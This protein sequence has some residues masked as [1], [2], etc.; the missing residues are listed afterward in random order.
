M[1]KEHIIA[2]LLY[3][4]VAIFFLRGIL[5]SPG[6]LIGSDWGLPINP[7]QMYQGFRGAFWT[8]TNEGDLLGRHIITLN[9][10]LFRLF[11]GLL[12]VFQVSGEWLTKGLAIFLLSAP[13]FS[14]YCL[15]RYLRR[16]P[17]A[18]FLAGLFYMTTPPVFNYLSMGWI[19][20]LLSFVLL[21]LG[22]ITF[23]KTVKQRSVGYGV[24]TALIYS[25]VLFQLQALSWF[26]IVFVLSSIFVVTS[27]ETLKDY[28]KFLGFVFLLTFLFNSYWIMPLLFEPSLQSSISLYDFARFGI[29]LNSLDM[30]RLWGSVFNFQFETALP[31]SLVVFTFLLPIFAYS[32]LIL[33]NKNRRILFFAILSFVPLGIFWARQLLLF[34][35]YSQIFRDYSRNFILSALAYSALLAFTLDALYDWFKKNKIVSF[36]FI[37]LFISTNILTSYPFWS[38]GLAKEAKLERDVRLK[39]IQF[40]PEYQRVE[41]WLAEEEGDFKVLW[42]PTGGGV[43]AFRDKPKTAGPYGAIWDLFAGLARKPGQIAV[44]DRETGYGRDFAE[45]IQRNIYADKNPYLADILS[46]ANIKYLVVRLNAYDDP[47]K[48]PME[49]IYHKLE[50]DDKFQE[51]LVDGSVVVF[52]NKKFLSHFYPSQNII[53]SDGNIEGLSDVVSFDNWSIRSAIFLADN[54]DEIQR[55]LMK[56]ANEFF[57]E[58]KLENVISEKKLAKNELHPENIAFPYVRWKPGGLIYSLV[59]KKEQF[60]EW[61]ARDN[62]EELLD[63]KLFYASKRISEIEKWEKDIDLDKT[64][65]RYKEKMEEALGLLREDNWQDKKAL[66][67]NILNTETS[68]G[69]HWEKISMMEFDEERIEKAKAIFKELQDKVKHL[70]T[71]YDFTERAYN[72]E[73]PKEGSYQLLIKNEE[74]SRYFRETQ[75]ELDLLGEKIT[76]PLPA[77]KDNWISGG[78]FRLE[79]GEQELKLTK[80]QIFNLLGDS[81]WQD[82]LAESLFVRD[83]LISSANLQQAFP[84]DSIVYFKPIENYQGDISYKISFDYFTAWG[85]AGIIIIEDVG[86]RKR[87]LRFWEKLSATG[88]DLPGHFERV[89]KSTF[90]AEKA[91]FYFWAKPEEVRYW[92]ETEEGGESKINFTNVKIERVFEP[93]IIFHTTQY[94]PSPQMP[95]ITFIKI[96]PTKY[97][98]KIEGAREPYTLVFSESFH[99][100]WKA[101]V[102]DQW[103]VTGDQQYGNIV[104][105]YF[106]GEIKERIHKNIFLDRNT[107][108]TWNKKPIPEE[109]HLL[110]NGY[111]NS[112][113]VTPEDS[114]GKE[115]YELVIEFWPQRIFYVGLGISLVALLGC[116][117][118]L[119][120]DFTKRKVEKRNEKN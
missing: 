6:V 93:T 25:L 66:K 67:Q 109:R 8:W 2:F 65:I 45:A 48:P 74:F 83:K 33:R 13:G 70:K 19:Y 112:W 92:E 111:A 57:I 51:V 42:L 43:V 20:L 14:L 77:E 27:R 75:L 31:H 4:F 87:E 46:L 44:T 1:K 94:Q 80:P 53:Y 72:F 69:A 98:V 34:I 91:E 61:R 108:E 21:P 85:E 26:A 110:V 15:C 106:D 89:I 64:L 32:A 24:V 40:S 12:S 96:N 117:G 107:F 16:T 28:L 17:Q 81:S 97:K 38:G 49:T 10:A 60:Y 9:D 82:N 52:E 113:Y 35:P 30:L 71:K 50:N 118:Y 23:E 73:I 7:A 78:S 47:N 115:N 90:G 116:L 11:L 88:I 114:D 79:K 36:I 84:E 101:Y 39:T 62:K 95:K 119:G 54:T 102:N 63:K 18:S 103:S 59:L 120:Y 58:A 56:K 105:S 104:A 5:P 99:E 41:E 29:R 3:F 55:I 37:S 22:L 86:V 100:G 68:L 76:I